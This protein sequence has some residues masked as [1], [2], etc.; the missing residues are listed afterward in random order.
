MLTTTRQ[1]CCLLIWSFLRH[2][3]F[4]RRSTLVFFSLAILLDIM[5]AS[6]SETGRLLLR[7]WD[8]KRRSPLRAVPAP[9]TVETHEFHVWVPR[10]KQM[11]SN[12]PQMF[13]ATSKE[14]TIRDNTPTY[15]EVKPTYYEQSNNNVRASKGR[16]NARAFL[17]VYI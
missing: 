2:P 13:S 6:L 12:H 10:N 5:L 9:A 8:S 7:Q 11:T 3:R 17:L 14:R 1:F 16:S 4:I 15:C